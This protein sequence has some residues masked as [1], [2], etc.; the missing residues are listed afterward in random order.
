M[1]YEPSDVAMLSK[2]LIIF[3]PYF[4]IFFFFRLVLE[5]SKIETKMDFESKTKLALEQS[6][7]NLMSNLNHDRYTYK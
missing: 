6:N 5:L 3:S 7:N 2:I 4:Y 1:F